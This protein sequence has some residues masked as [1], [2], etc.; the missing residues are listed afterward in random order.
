MLFLLPILILLSIGIS[1]FISTF[2][3]YIQEFALLAPIV[4]F[5][6]RL[7]PFVL[8]WGMFTALYIFMPNTK[9]KLKYA[10]LPGNEAYFESETMQAKLNSL[11]WSIRK[12]FRWEKSKDVFL[13]EQYLKEPVHED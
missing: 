3:N 5:L 12:A 11:C 2:V 13:W 7:T 9:V 6:V 1:I 10:I 8:T 4:K